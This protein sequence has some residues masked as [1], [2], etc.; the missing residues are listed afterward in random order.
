LSLIQFSL[1]RQWLAT[2]AASTQTFAR[3]VVSERG[4]PKSRYNFEWLI[5][6]LLPPGS[7]TLRATWGKIAADGV[8]FFTESVI[9]FASPGKV[10]L[11]GIEVSSPCHF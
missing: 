11:L 3:V 6:S 7:D 2:R 9:L 8:Y 5:P 4:A 1:R 10:C